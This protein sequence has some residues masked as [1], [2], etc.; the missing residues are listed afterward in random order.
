[1]AKSPSVVIIGA[2]EEEETILR[3]QLAGVFEIAG[4]EPDP[5]RAIELVRAKAPN[6]ALLFM[7]HAP[8]AVLSISG[9][10]AQLNGCAPVIVSRDRNPEN[11]LH[12]MR[13][14]AKD[15][16]FL[17]ADGVDVRRV[18]LNLSLMPQVA[19]Q[20]PGRG[21][22]VAVFGC[23]G[24][25]GS[26]AIATNLAG[27]L[28]PDGKAR[29]GQVVLLDLDLQMGDV[30]V[31]LDLTSRYTWR[32]L[33]QNLHRLDDD[34]VHQSLTVH[35][36]GLNVVAQADVLSE[37]DALDPKSVGS[38]ITFLRRHFEYIIIDGLRDFSELSLIALDMADK[39]LLAMTQDIPA[40]KNAN[41]CL[42]IL[43]QLGYDRNKVKLVVNRF[44]KRVDLD[45]DTISDALGVPVD[46]TIAN[47]F[48]TVIK[49]INEGALL[50]DI[51]PRAEVTR[52]IRG[53][54][55]L[56]RGEPPPQKGGLLSKLGRR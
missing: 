45:Q 30:L 14:G 5:A 51:A 43:R 33:V 18:L 2:R 16:A 10:I 15:F 37:A 1:M 27:A 56:I 7:D 20:A 12:A 48:P 13:A 22:V 31:F 6:I 11:I 29:K 23:K 9:K 4:T 44:L 41:R 49:A 24:G 21:M 38:A 17:E 35:P 55:P 39:I 36:Y 53:L 28:L 42:A 8:Q 47:D 26:T 3:R 54:V 46:A 52:D 40:L 34:L 19:T 50:V 32:D 25:S